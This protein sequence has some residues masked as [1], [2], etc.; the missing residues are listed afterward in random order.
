MQVHARSML[1]RR[2][3]SVTVPTTTRGTLQRASIGRIVLVATAGVIPAILVLGFVAM[4]L[5][6]GADG[7]AG[8]GSDRPPPP[9]L[10][11]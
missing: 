9:I 3:S 4:S 2:R 10:T 5:G 8:A 7:H 11:P 1:H 6:F